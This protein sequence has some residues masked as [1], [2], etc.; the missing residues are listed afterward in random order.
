MSEIWVAVT[1]LLTRSC[2]DTRD[3]RV[4]E[5]TC[6]FTCSPNKKPLSELP[7][8]VFGICRPDHYSQTIQ[9]TSAILFL[10]VSFDL[11]F[12]VSWGS[13]LGEYWWSHI[14]T[15]QLKYPWSRKVAALKGFQSS[16]IS[17]HEAAWFTPC[18]WQP[19]IALCKCL[20]DVNVRWGVPLILCHSFYSNGLCLKLPKVSHSSCFI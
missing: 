4:T 10:F 16:H 5:L 3:W 8:R 13:F 17:T 2:C 20:W 15:P 6:P 9:T 18:C 11:L 14:S 1:E 12:S 19:K 7:Q